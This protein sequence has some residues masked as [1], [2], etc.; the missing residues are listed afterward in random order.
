MIGRRAAG[1]PERTTTQHQSAAR[2]AVRGPEPVTPRDEPNDGQSNQRSTT[3][4]A[5][6]GALTATQTRR[7]FV[8]LAITTFAVTSSMNVVQSIGPNF[9][10]DEIGMN[11][12]LNGYLIAV[13]EL[14]G[15]LLIFVAALLLRLGMARATALSLAIMGIGYAAFATT[16][17][18]AALIVP[19]LVASIGFHSWLQLQSALGLSLA[20]RGEEGSILGRIN[21]IGFAGSLLAM[22]VVLGILLGIERFVG[23]L[24]QHQGPALRAFYIAA[25]VLGLIGAAAI[26]RFPTSSD[27]RAIARAA[28]AITWRREY[29]LYYW[30]SFLDGSRMQIYFAFAPFV[31]VEQ[32]HVNVRVLTTLLIVAAVINWATGAWIGRLVDR[33]GERRVLTVGY[34][35]HLV[36]FLGFA[37][38]DNVWLLYLCY[39][40]YNWLFLFSIGTTTYLRKICRREDL[41]PSLA[42]GVSLAHLTAIV[43]PIFGA[44]L[45]KQLGYQ[46]PFLFGT[47]FVLLSIISTQKIDIPRQRI[48]GAPSA[49]STDHDA[50]RALETEIDA[51][52]ED[53][54]PAGAVLTSQ[55]PSR[56]HPPASSPETTAR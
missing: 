21:A 17:S 55:L 4:H 48:A 5:L 53:V 7:G 35:L 30:L 33:Y 13:R 6:A 14:P 47:F 11:G 22:V 51:I 28:P 38:V 43:V 49:A 19:S 9:Y 2:P 20:K 52:P 26:L 56:P 39:L 25:G 34:C 27:E 24:R 54:A 8:L 32:F 29:R 31:L 12:A 18:F 10:R 46:F 44:A 16:H 23:D 50:E 42:M 3:A 45:W 1:A 41:A 36:V 37:L 40:G 15:F